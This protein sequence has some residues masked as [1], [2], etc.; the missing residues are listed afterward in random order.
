MSR[1][2]VKSLLDFP[3]MEVG[4]ARLEPP[5]I[6]DEEAIETLAPQIKA[7][8]ARGVTVEQLREFLGTH[9]IQ[10]SATALRRFLHGGELKPPKRPS[11]TV[12]RKSQE[13][14]GGGELDLTPP[15]S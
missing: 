5:K 11:K 12:A 3:A 8:Y 6:T 14:P 7:A 13:T 15:G 2:H 1:T 4:L 10:V 9:E